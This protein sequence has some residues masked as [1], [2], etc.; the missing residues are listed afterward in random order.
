[1]SA[2]LLVELFTEELPPKALQRL[3][4]AFAAGIA[5]GLRG[6]VLLDATSKATA[7]ATP[8]R[9][10]VFITSVLEK[11][12]DRPVEQKLMPA[13][14]ARNAD[15]SWSEALRKKLAGLGKAA[16]ADAPVGTKVGADQLAIK[17]D[18]KADAVF[19]RSLEPGKT[20]EAALGEVLEQTLAKLPI[21]KV[22]SY[23]LA[24]GAT[25][26]KFVRPAHGLVVLHGP[27]VL[28][29]TALGLVAGRIAHGHR[30]QGKAD[31]A[32]ERAD[33]YEARLENEGQVIARFDRRRTEIL[34]QLKDKSGP[35]NLTLGEQ[36]DYAALLDEV[37][38]LVEYPTVYIGEFDPGFLAVPQ[39]CLI[40][41][42]RQNQKYFPLFDA[43]GKLTNNF[44]IVS[45]MRLANSKNVVEGNQ[46]V[47]R[48][49]LADARFFFETD[50]KT[51]LADRLPQLAKVVY[52]NK[53]GTQ[54]ERVERVRKLAQL[55]A[56]KTGADPT[57][58]DRAA[59]LAKA[60]LVTNMVGEFPELQGV[61]GRYYALADGEDA[62][63]A[64]AIGDQYKI[65]LDESATPE[66]LV[67][68]SLFIADRIETLVGIWGIGLQPTG[69]KDPFGLRRAALGIISAFELAGAAARSAGKPAALSLPELVEAAI[70][71]FKPGTLGNGI[72]GPIVE[73]VYERYRNQ[74]AAT[75]D[76]A[77]VDAV[78]AVKPPLHEV[79]ARVRAVIDFGTLPEAAALAAANK[80]IGNILKKS[81]GTPSAVDA[82]LLAEP[83]EKALAGVVEKVRPDVA[84]RF[85]AHDY[86]GSLKL[87]AQAREPVDAF[88]NDVMVMA[89]DP[90]LRGN[91][92]ALL[93]ELHRLMNQ[94]ADLS[95]LA[96]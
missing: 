11:G 46:R 71:A 75:F 12:R 78:V 96:A 82:A 42:M 31:I 26:V 6:A 50:K 23:Q 34:Q 29:V 55:V 47:V 33:E 59:L 77:A 68:L 61:M 18:G 30:F 36:A 44:L 81:E 8:R 88:F 40:L 95:L 54:L 67:S 92:I 87:L 69:D 85:A 32:L 72:A 45:N 14:V 41:T 37:T 83:A 79:S 60:D 3:G 65:R 53:L 4:E 39:E 89:E 7:F 24:D 43:N 13:A 94:V 28:A 25:T 15:G 73:F 27:D 64:D 10:G 93:R 62:K 35:L 19:L 17:S 20:L 84:A 91:R 86:A 90:K 38:A 76:R 63:V 48:P 49:R 52:H 2:N 22:M 16:V 74:L 57:L 80:R 56:Q 58:A 51:K 5:D 70:A 9:L 66:N 1:M 21:P